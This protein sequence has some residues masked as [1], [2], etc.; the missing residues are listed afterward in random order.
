MTINNGKQRSEL[1]SDSV[2]KHEQIRDII[3]DKIVSGELLPESKIPSQ[4]E[5]KRQYGVSH[6]TVRE[7]IGSLV[8]EGLLY[9][10]QGEG[11]FVAE[12]KTRPVIGVAVPHLF[13]ASDPRNV[14]GY[15]VIAPL[16][17]SIEDE[18]RKY[19]ATIMLRLC[20]NNPAAESRN[21]LE[22]I[23]HNVAG[24]VAFIIGGSESVS[25][26]EIRKSLREITFFTS[27]FFIY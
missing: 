11:T 26:A 16:V 1:Q 19:E 17:T 25:S 27:S 18:A 9:R 8:H 4:N 10:I 24:V 15:E 13:M 22:L 14:I 6:N 2:L 3:R 7:A 21:L 5:M 20:Q 23:D 12:R